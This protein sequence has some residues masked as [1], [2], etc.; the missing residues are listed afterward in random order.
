MSPPHTEQFVARYIS[1]GFSGERC[2]PAEVN[3]LERSF[4]IHLPAAYRAFLLLMGRTPDESFV[5]SDC[6]YAS[7]IGLRAG[8]ERLLIESGKPFSLTSRD[9]V[10]FMHQGYQFLYFTC[11]DASEDPPVYHYME[12]EP[13]AKQV[14]GR[15]TDWMEVCAQE[16]REG[17]S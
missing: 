10:F 16:K 11:D 4:R 1:L 12:Y 8:A 13:T 5:G 2:T 9:F 17:L 7:L 3:A 6:A 15:F 14:Y